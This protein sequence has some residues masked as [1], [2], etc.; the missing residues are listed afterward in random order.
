L[1]RKRGDSAANGDVSIRRK[2][3]TIAM[4]WVEAH[5]SEFAVRGGCVLAA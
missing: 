5:L 3:S 4:I 1:N 2:W